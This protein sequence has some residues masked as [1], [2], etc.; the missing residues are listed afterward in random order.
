MPRALA[1]GIICHDYI[2][3]VDRY[4]RQGAGAGI[5]A[6]GTFIGGEAANCAVALATWGMPTWLGGNVLGD[7]ERGREVLAK[8]EAVPGLDAGAV[9]V[10]HGYETPHAV[11]LACDAGHR[12][13]IG[14]FGDLRPGPLPEDDVI[15]A[16][17]VVTVEAYLGAPSLA[18]AELAHAMGKPVIAVDVPADSPLAR[19]S[20]IVVNS[21]GMGGDDPAA[22]ARE[23]AAAGPELAVI[24]LGE[25]GC[26][27]ATAAGEIMQVPTYPVEVADS[28]GAGDIFRAGMVYAAAQGSPAEQ[29]LRFASAA[30]ALN[31]RGLGGCGAIATVEEILAVAAD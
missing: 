1:H 27:A 11:I 23:V 18:I 5:I 24:T 22:A 19:V 4:P 20:S 28:T 25:Q 9:A 7:D 13:I 26:V 17:D 8:L 10:E 3:R 6:E 15:G 21:S 12:T 29:S 14:K 2:V 31:C 30:A 16:A